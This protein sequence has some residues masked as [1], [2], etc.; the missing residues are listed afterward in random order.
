MTIDEISSRKREQNRIAAKRY[1]QKQKMVKCSGKEVTAFKPLS[2]GVIV[3]LS[4][5]VQEEELL[6]KRN[7]FLRSE[8]T[9]I[10]KEIAALKKTLLGSLGRI[11]ND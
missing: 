10:Q 5:L 8:A 3:V 7:A 4:S 6:T 1:R 11:G 9:R 2:F